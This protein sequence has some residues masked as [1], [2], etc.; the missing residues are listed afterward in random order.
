MK[1]SEKSEQLHADKLDD[2]EVISKF[3]ETQSATTDSEEMENLSSL[4][5]SKETE[6][7]I[8]TLTTKKT[9]GRHR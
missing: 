6:S 4:V 7:G 2:A 9:L 8:K 5:T 3:S 1:D